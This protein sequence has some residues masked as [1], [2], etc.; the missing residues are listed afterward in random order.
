MK[1]VVNAFFTDLS[2]LG[3]MPTYIL[4]TLV[5]LTLKPTLGIK[6]IGALVTAFTV[7][8]AIRLIYFKTRPKLRP[9]RNLLERLDASSFPSLHTMRAAILAIILSQNQIVLAVLLLTA[10]GVGY[11]RYKLQHH[12]P[13]D[14]TGGYIIGLLIGFFILSL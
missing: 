6:L 4:I 2:A 13:T 8:V 10:A 5:M 3:G 14:V 7:T 9:A 1:H 11:S 12:D